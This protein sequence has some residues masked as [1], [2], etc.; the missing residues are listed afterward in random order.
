MDASKWGRICER[1]GFKPMA[2]VTT[3]HG[4]VLVAERYFIFHAEFQ[5]PHVQAIW[6]FDRAGVEVAQ[7]LFFEFAASTPRQR[8]ASAVAAAE[9]WAKDNLTV[10]RYKH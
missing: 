2:P 5:R 7:K 9:Q 4:R 8:V 1:N 6:A 10:G 3:K